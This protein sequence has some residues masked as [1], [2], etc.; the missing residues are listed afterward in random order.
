MPGFSLLIA[1]AALRDAIYEQLKSLPDSVCVTLA[2]IASM[3]NAATIL[4][5]DERAADKKTLKYLY[6]RKKAG[7]LAHVFFLGNG[8]EDTMPLFTETFPQ[9]VRLGH[10][11]ARLRFH[12]ETAPLLRSEAILFGPYRL[13]PQHRHIVI[14][15]GPDVIRLTEKETA[16]LEYL[17]QA[18]QPVARDELLAAIWGYDAAIETHTLETHIYQLRRKLD[19]HNKGENWLLNEQGA[20]RLARA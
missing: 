18:S 11:L 5:L 12:L 7:Q 9:P 3:D 17:G 10:F 4:V 6:D 15:P 8:T 19:P 13:E 20:Y 16:L 2:S 1:D 14:L